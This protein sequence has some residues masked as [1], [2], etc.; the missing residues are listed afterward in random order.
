MD[1]HGHEAEAL[2]G[3]GPRN[4]AALEELDEAAIG[5]EPA[6]AAGES[7]PALSNAVEATSFADQG[8]AKGVGAAGAKPGK[9][10]PHQLAWT[11]AGVPFVMASPAVAAKVGLDAFA[12]SLAL[13]GE[14]D[15]V[16][17]LRD[18]SGGDAEQ[19]KKQGTD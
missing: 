11:K 18:A 9:V 17:S 16:R 7:P 14:T 4:A 15:P 12:S 13:E 2:V 10:E 3:G 6:R 19:R 5:R 1:V 8:K